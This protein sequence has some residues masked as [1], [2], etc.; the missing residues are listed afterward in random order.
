MRRQLASATILTARGTHPAA[1]ERDPVRGGRW[2][3]FDRLAITQPMIDTAAVW[4]EPQEAGSFDPLKIRSDEERIAEFHKIYGV[5][6]CRNG[7]RAPTW[8]ERQEMK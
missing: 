7:V 3:S 6:A 8:I 4:V 5:I 2:H 1:F